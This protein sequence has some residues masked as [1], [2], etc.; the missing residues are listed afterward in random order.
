MSDHES[1]AGG[2]E[3]SA[4]QIKDLQA[5][6]ARLSR[7]NRTLIEQGMAAE[8]S[9]EALNQVIARVMATVKLLSPDDLTET[10]RRALVNAL[11]GPRRP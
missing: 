3:N 1:D 9:I 6:V 4:V 2:M 11:E 7:L 8:A 10:G 5:H